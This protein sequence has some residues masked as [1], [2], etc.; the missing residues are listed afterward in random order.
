MILRQIL[1][2]RTSRKIVRVSLI[3]KYR[4]I[5]RALN[6]FFLHWSEKISVNAQRLEAVVRRIRQALP[7]LILRNWLSNYLSVF[8]QCSVAYPN[9]LHFGRWLFFF[10]P[11]YLLE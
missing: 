4:K 1:K 5:K 3:K 10:L 9:P 8:Q 7:S 11:V 2:Q 6:T